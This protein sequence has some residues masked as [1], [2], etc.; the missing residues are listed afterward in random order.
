MVFRDR[1]TAPWCTGLLCSKQ[2]TAEKGHQMREA[3]KDKD[4]LHP[5]VNAKSK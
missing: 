4:P 2:A 5:P 1:S 3:A